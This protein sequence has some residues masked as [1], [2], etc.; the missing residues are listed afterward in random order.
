MAVVGG[1]GE[2]VAES[3]GG[4]GAVAA[5]FFAEFRY[6]LAG[7]V[8]SAGE[9]LDGFQRGGVEEGPGFAVGGNVGGVLGADEVNLVI[10]GWGF[11]VEAETGKTERGEIG[12][13]IR[14]KS[15]IRL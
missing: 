15:V 4:E 14:H 7:G 9:L 11:G 12:L 3:V 8:E 10:G 13:A 1:I 5:E 2:Y 6:G